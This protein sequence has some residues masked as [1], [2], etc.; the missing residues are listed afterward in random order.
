M[1]KV[2]EKRAISIGFIIAFTIILLLMLAVLELNKNTILGFFLTLAVSGAYFWMYYRYFSKMSRLYKVVGMLEWIVAFVLIMWLS[3]PPV[4]YVKAVDYRNPVKT[5]IV[6]VRHGD[7][8]GVVTEDGQV[9][10]YAGIPYAKPPVGDLRWRETTAPESWKG[11]FLADHFGPMSMQPV[12]LPI[13]DSL[14]QII[15]YHDYK[16]SLKDNFRAPVSEDSLYLNIWKPAGKAEGLPVLVYVHGGSLKTGQ[17][18]YADYSGEGLA[19]EGV[20]V[21]NMGYR[22]GVFGYFADE[23]L[24]SESVDN[25]TGNY[26]LM[27]QIYALRWVNENIEAFGGDPENITLAGESAGATSVSAICVSPLAKGLFRRAVMESST[28]APV[29]PT[30]SFRSLSDALKSGKKVKQAYACETISELRKVN[31][32]KLVS[33]TESEHH[34]TVDGFVITKQPYESYLAGEFNEEA[35]IHGYNSDEAAAFLIFGGASMKNYE[36]NVRGYFGS[37][38]DEVLALYPATTDEEADA[39]WSEIWGAVFF[40]YPH[41]CLNRLEVLNK[42]PVYEYYFSKENGR[43]GPWHSGEEVYLYGNI[44]ENSKL[45]DESDRQLSKI[46]TGYYLNFIKNG[47]PNGGDLPKWEQ[48]LTSEDLMGFGTIVSM[49]KEKEHELFDILDRMQGF[50]Y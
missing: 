17:P 22:L 19:R 31:A 24:I 29:N 37:F 10:I 44:P 8:Q 21:V 50:K 16:I 46:M 32:G 5:D 25:T 45:Y 9:E 42:V 48:N 28:V 2:K 47:N 35:V 15:G 4:K 20:I 34:V 36:S 33:A 43:I 6:H 40:D 30:H 14:A 27:D 11:V 1:E 41:Y 13:Y 26:G 49:I 12:H 18:W 23:E 39:N 3:W 7:L 38:S